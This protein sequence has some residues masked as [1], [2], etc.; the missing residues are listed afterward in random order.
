[1][2]VSDVVL[3]LRRLG[4][5]VDLESMARYGIRGREILGVGGPELKKLAKRLGKDHSLALKLWSS[6]IFEARLLAAMV[7]EPDKVTEAQMERWVKGFDSWA[8]CDTVCLHL[9]DR[10]EFAYCKVV[11][12]STRDEEYVKRAAFAL[13]AVLAVHDKAAPDDVFLGF[14]PM[15]VRES[16]DGRRYVK[17]AVN[18]ALRQIGKRNL[19]LNRAAIQAGVRISRMDSRA[20]RW[21]AS[22]ALRELR[23]DAVQSR[24]RRCG[25]RGPRAKD[26]ATKD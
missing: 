16:A 14:L 25:D 3:E 7:D 26:R 23:G 19:R 2:D 17:K 24:L 9:F 6:G 8:V 12:W 5:P 4:R 1:M 20:A 15:I 22:D 11:E 21:I 18:W 10:T 13:M